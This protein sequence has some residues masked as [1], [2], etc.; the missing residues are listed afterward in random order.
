MASILLLQTADQVSCLPWA[1]V[2]ECA[3]LGSIK[4]IMVFPSFLP[5]ISYHMLQKEQIS[6]HCL[7]GLS[8]IVL[9]KREETLVKKREDSL[10]LTSGS[11]L[12]NQRG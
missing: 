6:F 3:M 4:D 8:P 12:F 9:L 7:T 5:T 11:S 10:F 2:V 1:A